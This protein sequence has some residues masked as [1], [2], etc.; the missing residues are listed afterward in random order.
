MQR[1]RIE[2]DGLCLSLSW[3][4]HLLDPR[5]TVNAPLFR[6]SLCYPPRLQNL[7]PSPSPK[8]KT[9]QTQDNGPVT[10]TTTTASTTAETTVVDLRVDMACSGCEA[11]VK[12]VLEATP[13]VSS[14]SVDLAAQRVRVDVEDGVGA[15]GAAALTPEDVLAVVAKSGKK[16]ELWS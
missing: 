2:G 10:T 3:L 11:A 15:G 8:T 5:K 13:G 6:F 4:L 12:R 7:S 9:K 1:E 16:A 14:V